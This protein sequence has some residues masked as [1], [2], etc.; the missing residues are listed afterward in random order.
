[1][2]KKILILVSILVVFLAIPP[3]VN[4]WVSTPSPIGF[5]PIEKQEVWISFY[6]SLIGSG[7]TLLGVALTICYTDFTSVNDT[8]AGVEEVKKLSEGINNKILESVGNTYAPDIMLR[9][10]VSGDIKDIFRKL[11]I[12]SKQ[13]KEFDLDTIGLGSTNIIYIALKLM[14]YSYVKELEEIQSKYF[15]LLFEEPEAH[16]HK[17]IQRIHPQEIYSFRRRKR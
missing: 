3:F 7:I 8:I 1:M 9:S 4:Y 10:E 5:I 13:N 11:K 17:H 6:A 12:K 2:K 14:E 15:I 16:L